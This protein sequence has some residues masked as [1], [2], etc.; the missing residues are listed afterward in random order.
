MATVITNL[1]SAIPYIGNDLV[2][3]IW[4]GLKDEPYYGDVIMQ[5]LFIAGKSSQI[6][7]YN[8]FNITAIVKKLILRRQSAGINKM[9]PQRLNTENLIFAYLVGLIE[10]DGW[11]CI[12]KK[13]KYLLYEFGIELNIRDIQLLYK[14]KTLLG[15]GNITILKNKNIVRYNIRNKKHLLDIIIP[16]FDKYP[17]LSNKQY[18]YLNFKE[19]LMN[20]IIYSKDYKNYNHYNLETIDINKNYFLPWFIGFIEGKGS[21]N[22]NDSLASFDISQTNAKILMEAINIFCK[23]GPKVYFNEKSNNYKIKVSSK[24]DIKNIINII[25]KSPIKLLGN[26]KLQF[27]LW[28]KQ[29]RKINRYSKYVPNKY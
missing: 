21:F 15:V 17:M 1:I 29:L 10:A 3:L 6:K 14:I 27:L 8:A 2:I 20:N 12:S 13:G 26:K 18:D 24:K 5:I 11:F 16:I 4:G 19:N 9:V 25:H 23:F 28:L 22:I 7:Y